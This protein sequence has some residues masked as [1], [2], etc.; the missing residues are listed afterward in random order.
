[1]HSLLRL[2]FAE[3]RRRAIRRRLQLGGLHLIPWVRAAR[4]EEEDR[5]GAAAFRKLVELSLQGENV[6]SRRGLNWRIAYALTPDRPRRPHTAAEVALRRYAQGHNQQLQRLQG[7]QR[8]RRLD[9]PV[10]SVAARAG[11]RQG[12]LGFDPGDDR[13]RDPSR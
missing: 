1:M 2:K 3:S 4:C 12:D 6:S 7:P 11:D 10:E 9:G 8:E 13:E 5:F